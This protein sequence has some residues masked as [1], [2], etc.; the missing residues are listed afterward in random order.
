MREPCAHRAVRRV[1][2]RRG[3]YSGD[4][5]PNGHDS[6]L[7]PHRL[8]EANGSPLRTDLRPTG[9]RLV[10]QRNPGHRRVHPREF[11]NHRIDEPTHVDNAWILEWASK[12]HPV[13]VNLPE[14][15]GPP[16][17]GLG[18]FCQGDG[19][20]GGLGDGVAGA[21]GGGE[22]GEGFQLSGPLRTVL[23]E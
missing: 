20:F 6:G 10:T 16:V 19:E 13:I 22:F 14:I 18:G 8:A 9:D 12:A 21:E 23:E 4:I 7:G 17:V 11:G 2:G 1:A 5:G 15:G 3:V